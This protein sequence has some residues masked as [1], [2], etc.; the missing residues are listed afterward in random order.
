MKSP[1]QDCHEM[2]RIGKPPGAALDNRT[3]G[4]KVGSWRP[5]TEANDQHKEDGKY[6][7]MGVGDKMT[8]WFLEYPSI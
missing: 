6:G 4:D 5:G 2:L 1:G 8:R 3:Y 7:R